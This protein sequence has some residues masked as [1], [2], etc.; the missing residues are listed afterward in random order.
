MKKETLFIAVLF[1]FTAC[2]DFLEEESKSQ[3]TENYYNTEQGLYEGVASVYTICRYLYREPMFRLN[4]YGDLVENGASMNNS[5][6]QAAN[7]DWGTLNDVFSR[8]HEGVMI[9]N[10][11]ENIVRENAGGRTREI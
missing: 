1:L 2:Q 5:Y 3:M 8:I 10:R 9:I 6:D 11:L 7:V 4:Y